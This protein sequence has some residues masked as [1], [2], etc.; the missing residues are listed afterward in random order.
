LFEAKQL[1]PEV[2]IMRK[3]TKAFFYAALLQASCSFGF[4]QWIILEAPGSTGTLPESIYG[5]M[6]TGTHSAYGVV[7]GIA[8]QGT[9]QNWTSPYFAPNSSSTWF[10]G[11]YQNYV[12]GEF[13][14][15]STHKGLILE[16]GSD[17]IVFHPEQS[18]FTSVRG[19]SGRWIS[20]YLSTGSG[21]RGFIKDLDQVGYQTIENPVATNT[22][23]E[24]IDHGRVVGWYQDA[25]SFKKFGFIYNGGQWK[26]L[27]KEGALET[28]AYGVFGDLVVGH[29]KDS[30]DIVRGFLYNDTDGSWTT[31]D[32]PNATA[33]YAK[34]VGLDAN[35]D[36]AITGYFFDNTSVEN[37]GYQQ[38]GF[39]TVPE[40]TSALLIF[41]AGSLLLF[42]KRSAR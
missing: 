10:Y 11:N 23:A 42:R 20:G 40:P 5:G 3:T 13:R 17:P 37:Y 14:E 15:G 33:T 21:Y 7:S 38:K 25:T 8:Y 4:S 26:T 35:G 32:A 6:V 22:Y 1:L 36:L 39:L 34:D 27:D 16:N 41:L 18:Q 30:S 2:L 9:S 29:F 19:I 12:V 24:D 31:L 28:K